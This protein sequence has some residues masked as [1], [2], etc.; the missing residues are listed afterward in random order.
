MKKRTGRS[1]LAAAILLAAGALVMTDC[2]GGDGG[3]AATPQQGAARGEAQPQAQTAAVE[4]LGT[5][6]VRGTVLYEGE[7]PNLPAV[8][9]TADPACAAQ[10]DEP[11]KSQVL[12]L[13]E[14][15]TLGNVFVHVVS[16]LP[17]RQWPTPSEP[18]IIDQ[19][20]CLYKPHVIGVLAGQPV[21][22]LNSDGILHN[23]HALPD[24]NREFNIAMPAERKE[25]V[26]TFQQPEDMFQIKCDVHPWMSAYVR[27]MEHPYFDTT[28]PDGSFEISGLPAGTF[29]LEAWH[30][31]L[32]TRTLTVTVGEGEVET[33]EIT[34][35][36]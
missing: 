2:G 34:L 18:A 17:E 19:E 5:A 1:S 21:K 12:E 32:G 36:R 24:V 16:G 8:Q 30:E 31:R 11:V 35:A 27:V 26:E 3:D 28:G 9:M 33:V 25:A 20:G 13:G 14:G 4:P 15:K 29:E 22:F 6:S 7:V 23:V 10:H